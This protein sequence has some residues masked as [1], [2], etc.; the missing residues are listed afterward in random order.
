MWG[1]FGSRFFLLVVRY[2]FALGGV[3]GRPR[4]W[5]SPTRRSEENVFQ[6]LVLLHFGFETTFVLL[7]MKGRLRMSIVQSAF[8]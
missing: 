2:C 5:A 4:R 6:A 1:R 7:Y 3:F 8:L